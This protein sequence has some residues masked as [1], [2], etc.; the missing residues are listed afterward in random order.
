MW[1]EGTDREKFAEV[2]QQELYSRV[3]TARVI[4]QRYNSKSDA[5]RDRTVR[6]MP[7]EIGQ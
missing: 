7:V 3:I 1:A 6:V 4:F 2:E 5:C